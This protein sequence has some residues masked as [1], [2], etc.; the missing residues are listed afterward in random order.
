MLAGVA[1][2]LLRLTQSTIGDWVKAPFA[3]L[4]N[5]RI[6]VELNSPIAH[7]LFS[8]FVV[9]AAYTAV[10]VAASWSLGMAAAVYLA[11]EI[12]GKRLL[13]SLF[14]LPYALPGFVAVMLWAFMFQPHGAVN[15]LFGGDLHLIDSDTFWFAGQRAFWAMCVNGIWRTWPFGFLML[16]A[17]VQSIPTEIYEAA[18]VDG[19][20]RWREF[21]AITLPSV[22][23]ISL[24]LLLIMGFWAFTDFMT[25]YLMF[26][27][28]AAPNSANLISLEIYNMS[29]IDLNFGLGAAMSVLVVAFLIGIAVL[30]VQVLRVDIG[31]RASA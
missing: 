14:I 21:R 17:G 20:S 11:D 26:G 6:S 12:R 5:F 15:V 10:I 3:G 27:Q 28:G 13:R 31:R 30:Y 8:S 7:Q 25:P 4:G 29:F 19:A 23:R 18:R 1:M 22:R 24:L 16:L 9:T 2:S